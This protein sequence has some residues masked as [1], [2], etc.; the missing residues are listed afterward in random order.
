MGFSWLIVR[1]S[2]RTSLGTTGRP[3]LPRRIFQV[4]NRRNPLRCHPTTVDAFMMNAPDFQ[5]RHAVESHAHR[6]RSAGVSFG[7][8]TERCRTPIWCRNA[9]I[10]KWSEARFRNA[11]DSDAIK[12]I[13]ICPNG[14]RTMSDKS[15]FLNAIGFT[16][17]TVIV[18]CSSGAEIMRHPGCG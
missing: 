17:T 4:Q 10:S 7:R 5:S 8:L 11:A 13:N 18:R 6:S 14:K 15:Y 12:A 9:R 1:I 2:S 16:R 3:G